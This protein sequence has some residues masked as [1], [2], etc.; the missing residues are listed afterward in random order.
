MT[1]QSLEEALTEL[2]KTGA[3]VVITRNGKPVAKL[4]PIANGNSNIRIRR[5]GTAKGLILR[6]ADDFDAP[7]DDFKDYM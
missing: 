6:M 2:A 4:V 7:L 5:A 1:D 3:D